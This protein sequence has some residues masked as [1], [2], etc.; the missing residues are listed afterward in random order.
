VA[1]HQNVDIS[2]L[3]RD[4][5]NDEVATTLAE[6][7]KLASALGVTGTPGYVVGEKIVLG[8]VG[9]NGLKVQIATAR[10]QAN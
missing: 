10:G 6:D 5:A 9:L 1:K 7:M 2:R 3:E 8:A 4:I